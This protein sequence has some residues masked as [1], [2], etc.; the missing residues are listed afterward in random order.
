MTEWHHLSP[1]RRSWKVYK[2][3]RKLQPNAQLE[4]IRDALLKEFGVKQKLR[5]CRIRLECFEAQDV[6][7]SEVIDG[8]MTW[9]ATGVH[10]QNTRSHSV[11]VDQPAAS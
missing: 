6:L 11:E 3:V 10:E 2:I 4:P 1:S 5:W 9:F 8:R 7:R